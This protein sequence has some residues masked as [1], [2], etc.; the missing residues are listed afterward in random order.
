M[1]YMVEKLS[2]TTGKWV[3]DMSYTREHEALEH[4]RHQNQ[5]WKVPVRVRILKVDGSL[6]V[7]FETK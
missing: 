3:I 7:V 4:A 1:K 2:K 6:A 5:I